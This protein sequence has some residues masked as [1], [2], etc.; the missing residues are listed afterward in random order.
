MTSSLFREEALEH[1]KDRLFG[2]VILLQPLSMRILVGVATA[3][4]LVIIAILFW[5]TYARKETVKGIVV[6][7]KGIVKIYAPQQNTLGTIASVQ[8]HEGDVVQAGQT[9]L[10]LLSERSLQGGGDIDSV[11]LHELENTQAFLDQQIL[12]EGAL[13]HSEAQRLHN[14]LEGLTQELSQLSQSIQLQESRLHILNDRMKAVESLREKKYVSET[15]YQKLNEEH[16]VQKQHYQDLLRAKVSKENE[17]IQTKS[18]LDQLPIRSEARKNELQNK[19]SDL[20]RTVA[21]V[22]GRRGLAVRAP[23]GGKVTAL[24]AKPGQSL[25]GNTPLMAIM[26]TDAV[27][28]VELYVPSRAIGFIQEGQTVRIRLDPFPYRRF[29][30]YEGVVR[31]ISKHVL[32]PQEMPVPVDLKEPVYRITVELK[33]QSVEA[34]GK[35]FP[36]QAGMSLE[37]DIILD[38]QSLVARI[39]D[40]ILSIK[41][42]L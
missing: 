34:Y 19:I 8:I 35:H 42:R 38:R 16:L 12:G 2:E 1:R 17:R 36:L 33:Q 20:K 28:Q 23:I 5:G 22:D 14:R 10:T 9:L 15:E 24:Q 31:V 6:P 29:G 37:A 7:D 11:S 26:P 40:P 30:I 27:F 41:G 32:I 25:A 3:I 21:E 18:E 4:C 39:F 13:Q